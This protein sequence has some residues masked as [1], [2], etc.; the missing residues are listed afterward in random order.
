MRSSLI[1][2][3]L[4]A[5]L[6]ALLPACGRTNPFH[7]PGPFDLTSP[8]NAQA[9]VPTST[10]FLWTA[11][12]QATTYTLEIST[13]ASFSPL[14]FQQQ[15]L[16]GTSLFPPISLLTGTSYFW[17]VTAVNA[18]GQTLSTAAPSTFTTVP[19]P[20]PP[21]GG[22]TL[23]SPADLAPNIAAPTFQWTA[24]S[25]VSTYTLQVATDAAF[26]A[27]LFE[28]QNI[29]GP[30]VSPSLNLTS[31]T[32]YFWK[33]IAIGAGGSTTA[34][35]APFSFTTPAPPPSPPG[36][37]TIIAPADLA[38]GL[39][40]IPTFSWNAASGAVSYT[41]QV[42]P[43]NTF[44]TLLVDR[45]GLSATSLKCPIL[46]D[47]L[48]DYYWRVT[49]VN[50]DGSTPATGAPFKFT[51][52]NLPGGSLDASLGTG[53]KALINM[54]PGG[55]NCHSMVIQPDGKIVVAGSAGNG[56]TPA[57][58][59]ARLNDDGSFDTTFN[60]TGFVIAQ[61]GISGE[62]TRSVTLQSDGKIVVAGFASFGGLYKFALARFNT[63]G[64]LD[65]TFGT[66][67]R[68]ITDLGTGG[69]SFAYGVVVQADGKI[70]A[71]GYA[72]D[73]T[74]SSRF[75]L[76]RYNANGTL[77]TTGF[78]TN[79]IT[80]TNALT[81]TNN[82]VFAL[83]IQ[84]DQKLVVAGQM[85]NPVGAP[86]A[87]A[88]V[89]RYKTDGTLDTAGFGTGGFTLLQVSSFLA[90][91]QLDAVIIQPDQKVLVSGWVQNANGFDHDIT[92][93]RLT[94]AGVLDTS[95]NTTGIVTTSIDVREDEGRSIALQGD[96]KI[97]VAALA[98]RPD[99]TTDF[100]AARYDSAGALDPAFNGTGIVRTV[101]GTGAS[102]ARAVA[103]D[104]Y[105]RIVVAGNASSATEGDAA[106]VRYWP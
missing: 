17:R 53:G 55:A 26:T 83:A 13:S 72:G 7:A 33:V 19:P 62:D 67:G 93:I 78:G 90:P 20:T 12:D 106:L 41:L 24:S 74:G 23:T 46:L 101:V 99:T 36:A 10:L 44:S 40:R 96:G 28:Q 18:H 94:T 63:D 91:S 4:A 68:V 82:Y 105:G 27:V 73:G 88:V 15:N 69:S 22:F 75:A 92:L 16:T 21:P 8:A 29:A 76:V 51:T 14:I 103:I 89:A 59:V 25:G 43:T 54:S 5:T 77:D 34:T 3:L 47:S 80:L 84:A 6:A 81:S 64:S 2:I 87:L 45:S 11:S 58:A 56:V 79:G 100:A 9:N 85:N 42:S 48:T 65:P 32:Q 104:S 70:V 49:A 97:V 61:M 98:T 95:F 37:F 31:S 86:N 60:G 50:T 38:T 35:N 39:S 71:A 52:A 1:R 57:F 66:G 30:P 102:D